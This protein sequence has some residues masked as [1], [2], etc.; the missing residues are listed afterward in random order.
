MSFC[1]Y[2]PCIILFDRWRTLY[3]KMMTFFDWF[4]TCMVQLGQKGTCPASA[5]LKVAYHN[6]VQHD[7]T[8]H[9]NCCLCLSSGPMVQHYCHGL[10][11][12]IH[13]LCTL[14]LFINVSNNLR[15]L[16]DS[17]LRGSMAIKCWT[18]GPLPFHRQEIKQKDA[19]TVVK[20]CRMHVYNMQ[21]IRVFTSESVSTTFL[22]PP[23]DN[24]REI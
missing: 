16:S 18:V 21:L 10:W 15:T 20:L 19:L 6:L 14:H 11:S 1:S 4:L 2:C 8:A 23:H 5:S 7:I 13:Y 22:F 9:G 17:S 12:S 24:H 3:E